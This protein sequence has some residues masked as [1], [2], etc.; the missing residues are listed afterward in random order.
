M[1]KFFVLLL[2]TVQ[3]SVFGQGDSTTI[4]QNKELGVF[5]SFGFNTSSVSGLG[6]SYRYHKETNQLVQLTGGI[7]SDGDMLNYT[8]GAEL[9][10][11]L[12][13]RRDLRYY[14]AVG[15]GTYQSNNSGDFTAGFG[16]GFEVPLFGKEIKENMTAGLTLFY[17]AL[18]KST[19]N[20][21]VTFG[22]SAFFFYNY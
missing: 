19:N 16:V 17:P 4:I 20:N 11:E 14:L 7:I 21:L 5:R 6:L 18:Y 22:I 15:A 2:F 8:V 13:T 10:I 1:Y 12:S 3:I 9:Q